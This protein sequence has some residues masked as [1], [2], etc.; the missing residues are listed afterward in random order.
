MKQIKY[1]LLLIF[2]QVW[3][4]SLQGQSEGV[5]PPRP[6][7]A[8]YVNDFSNWLD[9]SQKHILEQELR[10]M[11][12]T[13]STQIVVIIRP[14]IGDYDRASYATE[15]GNKWGIGQSE[16][17]NGIVMLVVTEG[18]QRGVFISTG[19]GL[20]GAMPDVIAS[21][22]ARNMVPYF[23]QGDFFG[24]IAFG[25]H[26]IRQATHGEYDADMRE[27]SP[28]PSLLVLLSIF[29]IIFLIMYLMS[30]HRG[31][32]ITGYGGYD[33]PDW[34]GGYPTSR[35]KRGSTIFWGGGWGGGS[36]GGFGGGG[37]GGGS[38]GGG[39]FGGGGG[40]ASW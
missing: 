33:D 20:E 36:G 21:R 16:K 22:I 11:H 17:D 12:D 24:G 9:A 37:F 25:V 23:Q 39:S 7:P 15:I 6:E 27:G 38:F 28:I 14:D 31:R 5:I 3:T 2:V 1:I 30:K 19:Y 40:G 8:V 34:P 35:Q 18:S 10:A 13:T 32:M 29:V 26:S 4:L